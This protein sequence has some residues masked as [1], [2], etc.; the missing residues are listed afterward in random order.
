MNF[1][2]FEKPTHITLLFI[3]PAI[4]FPRR[5]PIWTCPHDIPFWTVRYD[6]YRRVSST[7]PPCCLFAGRSTLKDLRWVE[8]RVYDEALNEDDLCDDSYPIVPS[9][10]DPFLIDP[11]TGNSFLV[12]PWELTAGQHPLV[13]VSGSFWYDYLETLNYIEFKR[14][15]R[16]DHAASNIAEMLLFGKRGELGMLLRER[17]KSLASEKPSLVGG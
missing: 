4:G 11:S 8:E 15:K 5:T 12:D 6:R 2:D 16:L 3:G 10:D 13:G 1:T 9:L 14:Q 17:C 7:C